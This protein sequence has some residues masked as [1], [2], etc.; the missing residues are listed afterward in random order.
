MKDIPYPAAAW[1][2]W[3]GAIMACSHNASETTCS[4][5]AMQT[6][7]AL[8]YRQ[9]WGPISKPGTVCLERMR[10]CMH[11]A[12]RS[13]LHLRQCMHWWIPSLGY[14]PTI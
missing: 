7:N 14:M 11:V 3:S 2:S 8:L 10:I 6:P 13:T 5:F 1:G 12:L 4:P 9:T